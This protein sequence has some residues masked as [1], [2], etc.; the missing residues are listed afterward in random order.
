VDIARLA[1]ST[2][3]SIGGSTPWF[4][5]VLNT[6][7]TV[8]NLHGFLKGKPLYSALYGVYAE[9]MQDLKSVLKESTD[10]GQTVTQAKE[11]ENEEFCEQQR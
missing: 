5:V 7:E 3:P 8:R 2:P 4:Q 6:A 1:G 10:K 9:V 11:P